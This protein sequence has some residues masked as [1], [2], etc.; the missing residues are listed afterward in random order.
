MVARIEGKKPK[1]VK[2]GHTGTL[3][4][5]ATGLLVVCVGKAT[6]QVPSLIK[7]DKTYRV[8]LTLGQTSTTLDKEGEITFVSDSVP[9]ENTLHAALHEF[10]GDTMQVPPSFS[11]LKVQGKRAYELARAGREVVLEPRLVHIDALELI[12]YT[13]PKVVFNA[14]VG[15][16]TYI[17]SLARDIGVHLGCGAYMSNLRRTS[18]GEETLEQAYPVSALTEE[19][20]QKIL[21]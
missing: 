14:R 3:D 21:V 8:E 9:D 12:D 2:V 1:Q 7:Q 16:G 13:Y 10:I 18:I 6:K 17:R 4:P 19:L 15:S 5:A 20:L 11:A